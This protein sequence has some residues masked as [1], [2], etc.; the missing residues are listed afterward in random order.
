[1]LAF[2]L[3]L[4]FGRQ[5]QTIFT[6]P[7]S[8]VGAAVDLFVVSAAQVFGFAVEE[9][10]AVAVVVGNVVDDIGGG[11]ETELEAPRA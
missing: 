5:R 8:R 10:G 3:G 6:N 11:D 1:M 4:L 9:L 2:T 7:W